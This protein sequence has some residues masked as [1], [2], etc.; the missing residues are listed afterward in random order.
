MPIGPDLPP[1]LQP[2][3]T[4]QEEENEEQEEEEEEDYGPQL[5]PDL[6][7]SRSAAPPK[8]SSPS[9]PP[10]T[11]PSSSNSKRVLGPSF[12]TVRDY[13]DDSD[14]DVGPRPLPA[15]A[16]QTHEED[17]VEKFLRLEESR[18][19]AAEEAK[20]P[21]APQREEWMLRPP[22]AS[23]LLGN[24]DPTKLT[25][26]RTFNTSTKTAG[27]SGKVDMS[28]WTETPQERQQR[29]ADEVAGKKRRAVNAE[30]EMSVEEEMEMRRKRKRDEE[31]RRGVEEHTVSPPFFSLICL[32]LILIVKCRGGLEEKHWSRV[33]QKRSKKIQKTRRIKAYGITPETCHSVEGSW[34]TRHVRR[35]FVMPKVSPAVL[36]QV[37]VADTSKKKILDMDACSTSNHSRWLCL[38]LFFIKPTCRWPCLIA[39]YWV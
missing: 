11:G 32:I 8:P 31:I 30:K 33:T 17:G 35:C 29:L 12:P 4:T 34:T 21:K 25:K 37:R 28:L 14:D 19:L 23:E 2:S 38:F 13:E 10:S 9:P 20:K 6:I 7:A 5:P 15:G 27:A 22:S 18:R 24:I 3:T 16:V 39:R 26:A 36:V 1:H